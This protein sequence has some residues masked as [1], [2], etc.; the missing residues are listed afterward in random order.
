LAASL[1]KAANMSPISVTGFN[2]D[3]VIE[4]SYT[5]V[6]Y[7][8]PGSVA[9]NVNSPENNCYYQ[10]NWPGRTVSG[11]PDSGAFTSVLDGAT[12][13]QFQ[14]YTSANDLVLG[15]DTGTTAGM[16]T[17]VA[18][19]IYNRIAILANSGSGGGTATVTLNFSDGSTW[20]TTYNAP[21]WFNNSGY[22]LAGIERINPQTG[23]ISGSG[24]ASG[25]P[26]FYQTTLDLNA[27]L[28]AN[29]KPL[30]SLTF[31]KA[32]TANST[33][34]YAIS[35][36]LAPPA[37]ASFVSGPT[38]AT[39]NELGAVSFTAA[40]TGSPFPTL[41]W[42]KN[43]APIAGATSSTCAISSA[44]LV[45]NGAVFRLVASNV[46]N[47]ISYVVT[48][49]PATLTV[50]ADTT[51]PVLLAAQSLGL[52]QIQAAFSERISVATATNLANY[53]VLGTNGAVAITSAALDASQSN[54]VL[55]VV[56]MTDQAT[57]TL[58]INNLTDQSAAANVIAPNSQASFLASVYTPVTLG[59]ATPAGSVAVAGT[60]WNI[61]GG[62]GGL[63]STNDQAQFAYVPRTGDFDFKV[64]LDSLTLADAWSEA[65]MMARE[66]LTAGGR[67]ISVLATPNIGGAFFE[68]RTVTN[69]LPAFSG[70]FP[71]NYPSTWLRLTRAGSAF[72]GHAGF[73]GTNWAQIG[74]VTATVAN[75][76]YLGFVV[77]SYNT[78]Q[79][80]TGAFRDFAAVT[81]L[82]TNPPPVFETLGQAARPTSLVISEIMYH[83]TNSNLEFIELFN[84]RGEPQDLT[85]YQ[86]AGSI[87]LT[88]PAGTVLPGAGFLVVAKSPASLQ[89]AYGLSGVMGPYTHSLP[90][91]TGTVQLSNQAGA[92]LLEVVYSDQSP[93]PIAADG[94]GH[95]LVLARPS[96]GQNNPMAWA[97][98]DSFGGS[99]GRLD[100]VTT[101]PLRNVVI[102][103][104]LAHTDPPDYDYIELYNH[105]TQPLDISGCILTDDPTTNKFFVPPGTVLPPRGFVFYSETN[106]NFKLSAIGETIYFKNAAQSRI[107]DCVR[108]AGQQNGVATGRYSD[109]GDQ[110][111]RLAAKT[112]GGPNAPIKVSDVIIN[113]I[114]HSP[115][116]INDDDQ[117]VELYN[118]SANAVNL[119]QW[120]FVSG[121]TFAFPSN[122]ILLPDAY[123]VVARNTSRMVTNYPNLNGTNLIGNFGG[124]LS[125]SGERLALAMRDTTVSTNHSGV[126][127]TNT[128]YITMDEV[129]YSSGG[130][131]SQWS[132][133]G[134]SS[135]ELIDP[136]SDHRRAPNWADSDETHK[137]PW[138]L[139]S[140]TGTIDNGSVAADELQVILQDAGECL[141]DNVQVLNSSGVNLITNS[142][143]ETGAGGWA[144][145]GTEKNSSLETTEGYSS[146]RSYHLRA[147]NKGDNQINRVRTLLSSA[148]ASGATN[149]TIQA[150]VRWLKG[151]PDILLR[152]RGN[153]LEC[154][155][156][157]PTPL[158]PG[159]PGYRNSRF[160]SNAPPAITGVQH[161][162]ILPAAGQPIIVTARVGD[163]DGVGSVLLKYRLDPSATYTSE[164][165]TD[166]GTGGD[167]VA[168]DGVYSATIPGQASGTMVAFYIQATDQ[169][170]PTAATGTFPNDA[171]TRECLVRVGETQP[172]GNFPV[173]R[174][175]MTQGNLNTW[176]NGLK[177]DN[178]D[179]DT[180]FVLG[181]GR[182]IYNVGARYKGSP[183]I[184]P[185][186]CGATCGRCGYTLSFGD[187]DLFLDASELV[188][189][190]PGGHGGETT[191]LEE[192][193]CYWL[194]DKLNIPWSHRYIIRLHVNGVTDDSRQATFEAIVQPD[195]S[196]LNE[197]SPNASTGEFF[198]I[199]R[200]FEFSD[201]AS[202]T[203]DPEPRLQNFTTNGGVKKREKYR[204]NFMFRSTA[205]RNNYT[206]IFSLVDA[207]NSAAPKPYTAA[208]TD[209]VDVEEWMRIFAAEHIT[210]N[211]D[212][213]GHD[214]GKN[215]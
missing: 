189:D 167:A 90:G 135:L 77:S 6:T 197:W 208:V 128:I 116:S 52:L 27:S 168:A 188:I 203:A 22:A 36:E 159:T 179:K 88:F 12:L 112:P 54:V 40:A 61:T 211:F 119:G 87:N 25:N 78:N 196:F 180:T 176:N 59:N 1:T 2:R 192:Q 8:V 102:N 95:S 58:T 89:A 152:L 142:T 201:T 50:L 132:G 133:A 166:D 194:D 124:K 53:T 143:F 198:K 156:E 140:A 26:R 68:S 3:V 195:G 182:V 97:A 185:G 44:A 86:L 28:G 148:L 84:S 56:T 146:A 187:D 153:W 175:W 138:T 38:N 144:A 173:Y 193:M 150:N 215:M 45:D 51:P 64:R 80:A 130:R 183:Y 91:G 163:P 151:T 129:T 191:A 158:N 206:N 134:G 85:G 114:M 75:T 145:E 177:L 34:I 210:V 111:Y 23:A 55:S 199:E 18:P 79:T 161:A 62:G 11:L 35:G 16:L 172:T 178:S 73:D 5:P 200:A 21:D 47:S 108:F 106:M 113:E 171:P 83:P 169:A 39:V 101:D 65:G 9:L 207:L 110:F 127:E 92:L 42:Q 122:T 46:V 15:A 103:E 4:K 60:G 96:Y 170:V 72:T 121:I 109:G 160:V 104:F 149:V 190:W 70:S 165:M 32:P 123:L 48:S 186:Y 74:G 33:G 174:V 7:P 41:Q 204:W 162:P 94:A 181:N 71:V 93:W 213:Y 37:P 147:V 63:G 107:L 105:S 120:Q 125:H 117:Y 67:F 184:S 81:T 154:A 126:L 164:T 19:A 155:A 157:L 43:G 141:L 30:V 115:V 31:N 29:N 98:S 131:W 139:I 24:G 214:I 209:L 212:A 100:P 82:G 10:S 66:D 118:R 76:L 137:A 14:P 136:H 49:S 69:G 99:P 202:L 13:F 20:T 205:R 57:Y 17:L